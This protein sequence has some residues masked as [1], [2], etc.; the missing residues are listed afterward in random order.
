MEFVCCALGIDGDTYNRILLHLHGWPGCPQVP[1]DFRARR[2]LHCTPCVSRA[3]LKNSRPDP[4]FHLPPLSR[5]SR[6]RHVAPRSEL[7]ILR[8]IF[9]FSRC[10]DLVIRQIGD[11]SR[12]IPYIAFMSPLTCRLFRRSAAVLRFTIIASNHS[13]CYSCEYKK[14]RWS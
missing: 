9:L 14:I 6:Q 1:A 2:V 13:G 4:L 12:I 10:E 5:M 7:R 8:W 3:T 11:R